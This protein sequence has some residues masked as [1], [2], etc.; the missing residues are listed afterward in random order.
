MGVGHALRLEEDE[1][2]G[3]CEGVP[4]APVA[5]HRSRR[6]STSPSGR[7]LGFP[8]VVWSDPI[9]PGALGAV[10][11]V[12]NAFTPVLGVS[13]VRVQR[14]GHRA[15]VRAALPLAREDG[16]GQVGRRASSGAPGGLPGLSS[17]RSSRCRPRRAGGTADTSCHL[18]IV[19]MFLGLHRA[20]RGRGPEASLSPGQ[21]YAVDDYT[22]STSARGWRSTTTSAWSSP[23]STSPTRATAK[24]LGVTSP[25]QVHL[26]EV[27][28]TRRR[29]RWPS[30]TRLRDDLYLDRRLDQP[31]E[32]DVASLPDPRQPARRAGSGS[33]ASCSS[34]GSIVCMWPQLEPDESRAWAFVRSG[35]AVGGE[36]DAR[37]HSR[38]HAGRGVRAGVEQPRR[39]RRDSERE[40][41]RRLQVAAVHVRGMPAA[42]ARRLRVRRLRGGARGDPARDRIRE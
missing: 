38:A 14:R 26:Q 5:A 28:P 21:T 13:L 31:A 17:T 36:R 27:S 41:A 20:S 23:T 25:A 3:F 8:A 12:F 15:G 42:S 39:D 35:T 29:R 37:D 24:Q 33:G 2:D 30:A 16:R 11:R 34:S 7:A 19:L 22:L 4:S 1:P 9:Y 40:G 32:Q 6:R 10:L 18:G